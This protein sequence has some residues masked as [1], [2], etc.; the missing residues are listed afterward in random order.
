MAKRTKGSAGQGGSAGDGIPDPRDR[1][2]LESWLSIKPVSWSVAVA[3][4]AALRV[5]PSVRNVDS[6]AHFADAFILECFR[7]TAIG[8]FAA[9]W[10]NHESHAVFAARTA[11]AAMAARAEAAAH[12]AL[13][14]AFGVRAVVAADVPAAASL[15]ASAVAAAAVVYV[16][17]AD[18]IRS[19]VAD[20]LGALQHQHL[21]PEHLARWPLWPDSEMPEYLVD[22][23]QDLKDRLLALDS[24]WTV[25]I[26][27]YDSVL[28]GSPP[29]P[30][31]SEVWEAAFTDVDA[32]LPWAKG[33]A[34]VNKE[35][36][37]RLKALA[38]KPPEDRAET[39]AKLAEVASP[40]P[41]LNSEGLLDAGP[42]P[43]F[44]APVVDDDLR[45]LP[46]RQRRIIN[47]IVGDLPPQA[48]KHLAT[49]LKDYDD[50]LKVR[51]VAPILG[52]LKDM[53]EI[54]EAAVHAPD[55]ADEWLS[56]SLRKAF[57]LFARNHDAIIEHFPLDP[58]REEIYASI[59]LDEDAAVGEKLYKPFAQALAA[60]VE[61]H[62]QGL[63]TDDYVKVVAAMAEMAKVQASEPLGPPANSPSGHPP[64]SEISLGPEDRPVP[65]SG[66]KRNLLSGI[67]F[68]ERTLSAV[69]SVASIASAPGMG[70][71][72]DA[73]KRSLE[74]LLGLLK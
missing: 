52:L 35:I 33:A 8:R 25:W 15:A 19:A 61:A 2:A 65:V 57:D 30:L 39:L 67:G 18:G 63:T 13:A 12:V 47:G 1:D 4:R 10:P 28:A 9:A 73:L 21:S 6:F 16:D 38:V 31:R 43:T 27:W 45:T 70:T 23:W 42:N 50:E 34:A 55:A 58:Q 20:D 29:A 66:K 3:A 11:F 24:G 53:A 44:D 40:Q 26:D 14:A 68:F 7:C 17:V 74:M 69:G 32:P 22:E 71:L 64:D 46:I 60:C 54:I 51:G 5:L 49:Y 41:S 37:A 48:P 62:R 72:T 36:A 59:P 56:P